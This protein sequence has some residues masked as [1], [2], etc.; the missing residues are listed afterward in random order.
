MDLA[1]F[2]SILEGQALYFARADKLGDRFEGAAGFANRMAIFDA[3]NEEYFRKAILSLP[4]PHS[5]PDDE[6]VKRVSARLNKEMRAAMKRDLTKTFVNCWHANNSESEALWRLYCPPPQPGVMIEATAES[7]EASLG[8]SSEVQIGR[9]QYLDFKSDFAGPYDRIF[10][11]RKS[12][13]HETEVRAVLKQHSPKDDS[14]GIVA[15]VDLN[16]LIKHVVPSPFSPAWIHVLL[17][18]IAVRYGVNLRLRRSE[19]LEEPFF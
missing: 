8:E 3:H 18:R 14:D 17:E 12:L 19:L 4:A 15:P 10:T 1:K 7:L 2:I 13:S 9:V 11:K 6:K 5:P 16:V